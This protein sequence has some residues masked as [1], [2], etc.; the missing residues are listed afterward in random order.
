MVVMHSLPGPFLEPAQ[1]LFQANPGILPAKPLR[2][3]GQEVDEVVVQRPDA[4]GHRGT[5]PH[6]SQGAGAGF[7]EPVDPHPEGN[8]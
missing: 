6:G 5:V 8:E 4:Q 7:P 1:H 3:D 2:R